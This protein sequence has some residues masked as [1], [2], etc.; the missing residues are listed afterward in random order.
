MRFRSDKPGKSTF[1]KTSSWNQDKRRW[2]ASRIHFRLKWL[3]SRQLD[4]D[5]M[6][7]W[8]DQHGAERSSK[9]AS[10]SDERVVNKDCTP[11]ALKSIE[12]AGRL[13]KRSEA[14]TV[15][16][17]YGGLPRGKQTGRGESNGAC[18]PDVR[19]Y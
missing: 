18:Q 5:P 3:I 16:K 2:F 14:D 6:L 11:V 17:N 13:I 12:P 19:T 9:F 1:H 10:M 4:L 8:T 7:P 15:G